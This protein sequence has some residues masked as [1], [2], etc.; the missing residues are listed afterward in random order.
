MEREHSHMGQSAAH[1]LTN[2][3]LLP[4]SSNPLQDYLFTDV[5]TMV[6]DM[7]INPSSNNGFMLQMATEVENN[8]LI[9]QSLDCGIPGKFPT[10]TVHIDCSKETSIVKG[11]KSYT[12]LM[13]YPNPTDRAL[14]VSMNLEQPTPVTVTILDM[15]GRTVGTYDAGVQSAGQQTISL[16]QM[17]ARFP[18]G[19]YIARIGLGGQL[20]D[21]KLILTAN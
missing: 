8:G 16:D 11:V 18:A 14:S 2:A 19:M 6:Q 3:A 10:L 12:D 13:I 21:K 7:I 4:Q 15:N 1:T 9:F 17:V 5:T 20:V